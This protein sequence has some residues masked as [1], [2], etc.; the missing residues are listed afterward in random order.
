MPRRSPCQLRRDHFSHNFDP[1]IRWT[2]SGNTGLPEALIDY[3]AKELNVKKEIAECSILYTAQ[4]VVL[5][6]SRWTFR[7]SVSS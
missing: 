7:R 3:L 4:A 1:S 6:R 5:N 2:S